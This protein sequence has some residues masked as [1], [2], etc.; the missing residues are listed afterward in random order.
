MPDPSNLLLLDVFHVTLAALA[1]GLIA[2]ALIRRSNALIRWHEH[3]NVWTQPF[4]WWNLA[5]FV[6]VT[7]LFYGNLWVM[8]YKP[9]EVESKTS[10]A[11]DSEL[12]VLILAS[13]LGQ[14]ILALGL[15][16][17]M[18]A[19]GHNILELF[20]L[21]RLKLEQIA[22]WSIGALLLA[23]PVII[24]VAIG[25]EKLLTHGLGKE[26]KQQELVEIFQNNP[27]VLL[28]AAIVISACI[29]APLF[30][31]ILF[32]GFFYATLK[33]FSERF[34]AAIVVSLI[35]AAIHSNLGSLLPLFV[36]AMAIT[37]AY[38]LTGC[39]LV[40]I[41]MHAIFNTTMVTLMFLAPTGS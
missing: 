32:R 6:G 7:A 27:S 8:T 10:S 14:G 38:E 1:L 29:L 15:V 16:F 26:Q 23:M 37:I 41:A 13:A 40:P 9:G 11:S 4:Q 17:V 12:A 31:E 35:F 19:R 24:G 2:F 28:Q 20:G 25:W 22:K 3:G 18:H 5:V 36:L 21:T 39:L 33:R 34:F 30:E